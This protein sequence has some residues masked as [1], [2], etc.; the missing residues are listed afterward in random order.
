LS[1]LFD[2][3][4]AH[5]GLLFFTVVSVALVAYLLYAMINPSRF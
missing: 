3:V 2:Y 4:S 5:P 1:G